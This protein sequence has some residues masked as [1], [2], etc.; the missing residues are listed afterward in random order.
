MEQTVSGTSHGLIPV[1]STM[2]SG[3]KTLTMSKKSATGALF[4]K[5]EVIRVTFGSTQS[6]PCGDECSG[7]PDRSEALAESSP[8]TIVSMGGND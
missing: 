1:T 6:S 8:L 7:E 4:T 2:T 3:F 5:A